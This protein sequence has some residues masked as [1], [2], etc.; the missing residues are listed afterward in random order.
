MFAQLLSVFG[1]SLG[2][3]IIAALMVRRDANRRAN[4]LLAGALFCSSGYLVSTAMIRTGFEDLPRLTTALAYGYFCAPPLLYGYVRELTSRS[5]GRRF[6]GSH[7][8]FPAGLVVVATS[9]VIEALYVNAENLAGAQRGWPP[10]LLFTMS[11][12]MY[13]V[14]VSYLLL[15]LA[16]LRRHQAA[17]TEIF[18]FQEKVALNW[19][20]RLLLAYL[21]LSLLGFAL[22]VVRMLPDVELWPRSYYSVLMLISVNY[23]I[24]FIGI[25]Q[26]MV[27][28]S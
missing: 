8:L 17:V 1:V 21:A 7:M 13:V 10:S 2:L 14:T 6:I 24:A 25:S 20:K 18:S 22:S 16:T 23:L 9:G 5:P 11:V 12:A 3:L 19:L 27:F 28:A 4:L 15:S 26:P